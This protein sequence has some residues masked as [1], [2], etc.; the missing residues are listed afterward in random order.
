MEGGEGGIPEPLKSRNTC[1]L[2]CFHDTCWCFEISPLPPSS[3]GGDERGVGGNP[4]T[5]EIQKR[6]RFE[7]FLRHIL[8]LRVAPRGGGNLRTA[9]IQKCMCFEWFLRHILGHLPHCTYPTKP[10]SKSSSNPSSSFPPPTSPTA[11]PPRASPSV[12]PTTRRC[13]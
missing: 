9:G 3:L 1:V 8:V 12:S 10:T 11:S 2:S 7:W 13:K 6:I 4:R 5:A